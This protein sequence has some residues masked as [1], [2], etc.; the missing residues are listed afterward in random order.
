MEI[1]ICVG[2]SCHIKGS[3]EIVDML[4]A[5]IEKHGLDGCVTLSGS[6]CTGQCNRL[7][8]TVRVEDE[9]CTGITRENFETFFNEKILSNFQPAKE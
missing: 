7:G 5:A 8:V 4:Q 6:F 1:K 2:S 3:S 9:I